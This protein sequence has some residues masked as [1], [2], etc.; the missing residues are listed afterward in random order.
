MFLSKTIGLIRLIKAEVPAS[1]FQVP[2]CDIIKR[3]PIPKW[4]RVYK[5]SHRFEMNMQ[6]KAGSTAKA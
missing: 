6:Q 2:K 4:P 5:K 3:R 1:S